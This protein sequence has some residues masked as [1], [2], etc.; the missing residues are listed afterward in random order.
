MKNSPAP[1]Q[2]GVGLF[3]RGQFKIMRLIR[4]WESECVKRMVLDYFVNFLPTFDTGTV[5]PGG[6]R[7]NTNFA[8]RPNSFGPTGAALKIILSSSTNFH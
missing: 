6:G 8:L 4:S 2:R 3:G 5:E 1:L 7:A